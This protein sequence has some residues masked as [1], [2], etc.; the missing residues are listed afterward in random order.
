MP[1]KILIADD[2]EG[3]RASHKLAVREASKL[4]QEE[5]VTVEAENSVETRTKMQQEHFDL[6]LLDNEFKDPRIKGH[7]PGIG[8]L[9]LARRDGPNKATPIIF[10]SA[11][12][13]ETLKPMVER[14]GGVFFPKATYDM[15]EVARLFAEQLKKPR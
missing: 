2:D 14:F 8:L 5:C 10:C 13:F 11:E 4:L 12:S 15:D 9:Q 1:K 3:V 6:I 7:L